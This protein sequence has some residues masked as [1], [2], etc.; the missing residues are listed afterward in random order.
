MNK[1]KHWCI[2]VGRVVAIFLM[3]APF[4]VAKNHNKYSDGDFW[5]YLI[6]WIFYDI[7]MYYVIMHKD[8]Q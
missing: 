7:Y 1:I 4:V 8:K 3:L 5:F 6:A 2:N